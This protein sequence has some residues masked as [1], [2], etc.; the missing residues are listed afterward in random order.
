M[1]AHSLAEELSPLG[2]PPARLD[3]AAHF[4]LAVIKLGTVNLM[5]LANV[6]NT[7]VQVDSNYKRL[8][9]FFHFFEVDEAALARW[10]VRGIE[11][12]R[13]ILFLDRTNWKF[14]RQPINILTL[15]VAYRGIAIR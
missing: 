4:I 5:R 9:R 11:G 6:F 13:W 1:N 8:Q 2:W 10:L 3:L 7:A 14:G 12:G 15:A